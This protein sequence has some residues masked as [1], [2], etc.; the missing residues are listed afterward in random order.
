MPQFVKT[1][2]RAK[3][4]KK[5]AL[6]KN[7]SATWLPPNVSHVSFSGHRGRSLK[8]P[9][10]QVCHMPA[11][12]SGTVARA[13]GPRPAGEA[14]TYVVLLFILT[15]MLAIMSR[16]SFPQAYS[17]LA[18]Y[19]ST[20]LPWRTQPT[21]S[22][23]SRRPPHTQMDVLSSLCLLFCSRVSRPYVKLAQTQDEPY[24]SPEP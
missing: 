1:F 6:L 11:A 3:E 17:L 10:A 18:I 5:N 22:Q 2:K 9:R 12:R 15:Y 19:V 23:P 24:R 4:E 13:C 16:T 7:K 21:S 8:R 14:C 20:A